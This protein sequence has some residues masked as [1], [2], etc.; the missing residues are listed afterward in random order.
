MASLPAR[1]SRVVLLCVGP[2]AAAYAV[3]RTL[4]LPFRSHA[5]LQPTSASSTSLLLGTAAVSLAFAGIVLLA[6][7]ATPSA[8]ALGAL[9]AFCL[10][11]TPASP[12]SVLW[13]L[14][15]TLVLTISASRVGRKRKQAMGMGEESHG[16]SAAQVAANVGVGALAGALV[17]SHGVVLAHV[18]ML[19]ALGE[20]TADTLASELGQLA[21]APPRMLLTGRPVAPGTDGAVSLP[22]TLA[23]IGGAALLCL[24]ARW[25]LALPWAPIAIAGGGAVFGLFFD[26]L[27]GQ[28]AERRGLL[29]NDAVNFLSTLAAALCALAVGHLLL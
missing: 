23:G 10:G 20:A 24:A 16:R 13:L 7:A 17:P 3:T 6:R 18:A 21:A 4:H 25:A 15:L 2:A 26:S 14:P 11:V 9:L 28:L 19:A 5:D 1:Q 29:N 12:H 22:G 8:A 27:L